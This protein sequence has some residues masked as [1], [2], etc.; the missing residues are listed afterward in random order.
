MMYNSSC[1]AAPKCVLEK[2]DVVHR[3]HLR[4]ILNY[5]Y[6]IYI[7]NDN[8]YKRCNLEPLSVRVDR[9]RWRMLGH[10]LRGPT[11]SPAYS[12]LVFAINTLQYPG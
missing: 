2:L 3:R 8:L 5:C 11:E 6:L 12:S 4:K 7:S 9:N 10:V 1:W